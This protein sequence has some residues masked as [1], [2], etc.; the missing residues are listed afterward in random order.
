MKVDVLKSVIALG[1][2]ALLA[3]AC[4]EICDH[5][6]LKMTI[7]TGAFVALAIPSLLAM[8]L[9]PKQERRAVVLKTLSWSFFIIEILTNAIFAFCKFST[10]TF[11][12]INGIIILLFVVI[13]S[14]IFKAKM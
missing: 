1:I 4:Y 8:G 9:S 5:G 11:I 13:Y 2:S 7:A 10:P 3:Y 6:S 12:I 14:S